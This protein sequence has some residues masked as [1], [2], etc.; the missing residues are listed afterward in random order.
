MLRN[1]VFSA[2]IGAAICISGIAPAAAEEEYYEFG[3]FDR[4]YEILNN[5]GKALPETANF[6][7]LVS[8][9]K[10][11]SIVYHPTEGAHTSVKSVAKL[12]K[13]EL[14]NKNV[15]ALSPQ[16]KR[17]LKRLLKNFRKSAKKCLDGTGLY[18]NQN[19]YSCDSFAAMIGG[20]AKLTP[21]GLLTII[22]ESPINEV[23]GEKINFFSKS[24]DDVN[25]Q[26]LFQLDTAGK[27]FPTSQLTFQLSSDQC[28]IINATR[29]FNMAVPLFPIDSTKT[30][31]F[32]ELGNE[33]EVKC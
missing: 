27:S 28:A 19:V 3:P 6:C 9:A 23:N 10:Q 8:P 14:K 20:Q 31:D 25:K 33:C 15:R 7:C 2:L 16:N 29:D 32:T 30:G 5:S 26:L 17:K 22:F 21:T 24:K 4:F 18:S 12:Y 13:Q 11:N 1:K